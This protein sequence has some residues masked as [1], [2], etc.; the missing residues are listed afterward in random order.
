M[1]NNFKIA[2]FLFLIALSSRAEPP[3]DY[4]NVFLGF[5]GDNGQ[6]APSASYLFV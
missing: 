2:V 1:I 3:A 6:M 5:W 4:V